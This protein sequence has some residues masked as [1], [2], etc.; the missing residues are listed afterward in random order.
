M[1][2]YTP[3]QKANIW[4]AIEIVTIAVILVGAFIYSKHLAFTSLE[5]FDSDPIQAERG[6]FRAFA[7]YAA[8]ITIVLYFVFLRN[9]W[10][11]IRVFKTGEW[12]PQ[13]SDYTSKASIKTGSAARWEAAKVIFVF[14]P[15]LIVPIPWQYNAYHMYQQMKASE[16]LHIKINEL[17]KDLEDCTEPASKT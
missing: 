17:L 2:Y 8:T 5:L 16:A 14:I 12:P 1:A 11:T 9:T 3:P 15:F 4:L 7:I 6:V 10:F 13:N